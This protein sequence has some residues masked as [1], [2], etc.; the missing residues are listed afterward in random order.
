MPREERILPGGNLPRMQRAIDCGH[1]AESASLSPMPG[2][3]RH[4]LRPLAFVLAT[5]LAATALAQAPCDHTLVAGSGPE[6]AEQL[7]AA[8][9]RGYR[10]GAVAR[11]DAS[12]PPVPAIVLLTRLPGSEPTAIEL[13]EALD[14]PELEAAVGRLTSRGARL[15]GVTRAVAPGGL[16][17]WLAVLEGPAA[18][19]GA[20]PAVAPSSPT[21]RLLRSRGDAA[22][23]RRLETAAGEGFRV[24]D[25]LWW[26]D[27]TRS[28]LSEVVFVLERHPGET[29]PRE[30]ELVWEPVPKLDAALE[31]LAARGWEADV[32]WTSRDYVNVLMSRPRGAPPAAA[33]DRFEVD[34]DPGSPTVSSMSGRLVERLAFR[35]GQVAIYERGAAGEG[36]ALET[37]ALSW[38]LGGAGWARTNA[39][40]GRLGHAGRGGLCAFDAVWRQAPGREPELVVMLRRPPGGG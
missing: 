8:A 21:Y 26:P 38:P 37:V 35:A 17:S 31:R 20:E 1:S 30:L 23:W 6:L 27:P 32:A 10:V 2:L 40:E 7:A 4:R 3:L 22:E 14:L 11:P 16:A 18:A 25:V 5:G 12:A 19:V 13:A 34:E 33:G 15:R 29:P 24:V 36:Y 39:V 9:A 28:A